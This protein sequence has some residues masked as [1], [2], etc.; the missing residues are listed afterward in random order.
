LENICW[1]DILGRSSEISHGTPPP[2][3]RCRQSFR[4]E[5]SVFECDGA[6][7]GCAV[8]ERSPISSILT[9]CLPEQCSSKMRN[10]ER[11]RSLCCLSLGRVVGELR[12]LGCCAHLANFV[13]VEGELE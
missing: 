10:G 4:L 3:S 8:L 7:L 2:L 12:V 13:V 9:E 1:I 5:V 6:A 11:G